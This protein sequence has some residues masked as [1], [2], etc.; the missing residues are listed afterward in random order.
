MNKTDKVFPN[1]FSA[2]QETHFEVVSKLQQD[3]FDSKFVADRYVA[4]GIGGMY[5]LAEELTDE[6]ENLFQGR[7]WMVI[8]LMYWMSF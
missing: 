3:E 4:S 7:E 2:W 5:E 1:G 8:F 6:F